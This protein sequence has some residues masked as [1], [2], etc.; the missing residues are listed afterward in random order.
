MRYFLEIRKVEIGGHTFF[1]T[2][3]HFIDS[4]QRGEVLS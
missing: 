3:N 4:N 1:W 2:T